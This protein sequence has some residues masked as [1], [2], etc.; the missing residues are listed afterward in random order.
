MRTRIRI[1]TYVCVSA[2]ALLLCTMVLSCSGQKRAAKSGYLCREH[3]LHS[4]D[5]RSEFASCFQ[6]RSDEIDQ[7]YLFSRETTAKTPADID[8]AANRQKELIADEIVELIMGRLELAFGNDIASRWHLES[9]DLDVPFRRFVFNDNGSFK[10]KVFAV[11]RK[12]D[13]SPR[14]L[15]R[16]L[17]LEYKMNLMKPTDQEKFDAGDPKRR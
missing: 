10:I 7:Y 12:D 6:I 4:A 9:I 11:M 14:S 16:F 2:A 17:P 8:A 3:G 1:H 15:I 13:L 5:D